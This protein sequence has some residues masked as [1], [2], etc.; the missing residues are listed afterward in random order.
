MGH[1]ATHT[2]FWGQVACLSGAHDWSGWQVQDA[3][4]LDEQVRVCRRCSRVKTN[5]AAVPIKGW[6][7]PLK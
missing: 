5:A 7:M 1:S 4:R 2:G 6:K 3:E